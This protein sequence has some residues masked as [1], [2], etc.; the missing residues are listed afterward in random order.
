MLHGIRQGL[1]EEPAQC[2]AGREKA[3]T[4]V[5]VDSAKDFAQFSEGRV[6]FARS[7]EMLRH[8]FP[9][10]RKNQFLKAKPLKLRIRVRMNYYTK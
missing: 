8:Y 1:L 2:V 6:G 9:D 5:R 10:W 4:S 3:E 7:R